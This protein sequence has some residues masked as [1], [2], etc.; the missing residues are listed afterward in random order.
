MRPQFL[1]PLVLLCGLSAAATPTVAEPPAAR[2]VPPAPH[3]FDARDVIE[4]RQSDERT[5]ALR[6]RDESRYRVELADA[7]PHALFAERARLV[8]AQGWIC[9]SNEEYVEADERRCALAGF[10]RID[11][12]EYA[13]HAL[14]SRR[15]VP[16]SDDP[17]LDTIRVSARRGRGFGGTTA[18]CLDTRHMRGWSEDGN[19]LIVEVSPKRSGGHRYYRVEL[20]GACTEMITMDALQLDSP[21]GG[22]AF[23]GNPG[24]RAVFS[25]QGS[26]GRLFSAGIDRRIAESSLAARAGCMVSRVYPILPGERRETSAR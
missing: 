22:T 20:A 17:V 15:A 9:G 11:A 6:L 25:R 16:R 10:A 26:S 18:F 4:A 23:C 2:G 21:T 1:L 14:R 8:S 5:I 24:D 13:D 19:D 7:C 12:R 3:C